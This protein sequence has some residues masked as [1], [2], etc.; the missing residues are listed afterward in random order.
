MFVL[1]SLIA[2]GAAVAFATIGILTLWGGW[3]AFQQELQRGFVSENTSAGERALTLIL[4]GLPLVGAAV[5]GL[6]SALRIAAVAVG[7]G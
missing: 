3:H 5:F 2:I 7:A 1:G 4:V 6:L